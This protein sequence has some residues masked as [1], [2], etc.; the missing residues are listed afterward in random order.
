MKSETI[1]EIR[2]YGIIP[3]ERKRI[4][5]LNPTELEIAE[6]LGRKKCEIGRTQ[7]GFTK[8]TWQKH[9]QAYCGEIAF[10]KMM[11]IHHSPLIDP[12]HNWSNDVGDAMWGNLKVDVKHSTYDPATL[13][14]Q[15]Y[16][17][18]ADVDIYAL[19]TGIAAIFKY[20]GAILKKDLIIDNNLGNGPLGFEDAYCM[21]SQRLSY[22]WWSIKKVKA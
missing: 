5:E 19:I 8:D 22:F 9:Y 17:I 12:T 14:V 18:N 21:H 16:A 3:D 11:N 6:F 1:L 7:V 20:Q 2:D 13:A 4:V 10:C 15:R